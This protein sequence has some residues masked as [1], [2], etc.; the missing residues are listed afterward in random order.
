[1]L[2]AVYNMDFYVFSEFILIKTAAFYLSLLL[3]TY[4]VTAPKKTGNARK[5]I[6]LIILVAFLSERGIEKKY[7][8][9]TMEGKTTMNEVNNI[10]SFFF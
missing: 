4:F 9:Q 7:I 8:S 6:L 1:M 5:W 10:Q 2:Q 3:L